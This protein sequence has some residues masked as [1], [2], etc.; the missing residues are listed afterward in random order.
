MS[1]RL[2]RPYARQPRA[3]SPASRAS[4]ELDAGPRWRGLMAPG[5]GAVALVQR[6]ETHPTLRHHHV[7]LSS[8]RLSRMAWSSASRGTARARNPMPALSR[9]HRLRARRAMAE[10][11]P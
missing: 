9:K 3:Q 2:G 7:P 1:A 4:R 10:V 6:S 8:S 5:L 11:S